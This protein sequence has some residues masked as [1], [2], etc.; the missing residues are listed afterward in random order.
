MGM[1]IRHWPGSSTTPALPQPDRFAPRIIV[2][3]SASG[4]V[5]ASPAT[6]IP[7]QYVVDDLAGA[8]LGN[9]GPGDIWIR[10]GSYTLP[11]AG[12]TVSLGIGTI[13]GGDFH[14]AKINLNGGTLVFPSYVNLEN[15]QIENGSV[16]HNQRVYYRNCL[17][18]VVSF[19]ANEMLSMDSCRVY[20]GAGIFRVGAPAQS[21]GSDYGYVHSTQ[22]RKAVAPVV[23]IACPYFQFSANQ[24]WLF[25]PQTLGT[26]IVTFAPTAVHSHCIQ[27]AFRGVTDAPAAI[28]DQTTGTVESAHN[29]FI[30]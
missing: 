20:L 6:A 22:I 14:T 3:S 19:D 8:L 23:E 26:P 18:D 30:P 21:G 24:I 12:L 25:S 13:R 28:L 7:F 29:L 16:V 10:P 11:A 1:H 4:D 15:L 2:G 9:Y 27:I 5:A 17:L